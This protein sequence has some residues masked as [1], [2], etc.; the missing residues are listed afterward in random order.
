MFSLLD[1]PG[2]VNPILSATAKLPT[3]IDN[4]CST[5]VS[6]TSSSI[7]HPPFP[8]CVPLIPSAL[9]FFLVSQ[10]IFGIISISFHLVSETLL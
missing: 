2:S 8:H 7:F 3:T 6:D 9:H 10:H 1:L 5:A 4:N